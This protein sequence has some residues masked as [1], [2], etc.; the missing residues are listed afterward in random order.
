MAPPK[1][2]KVRKLVP[3]KEREVLAVESSEETEEE[4]NNRPRVPPQTTVRGPVQVDVLPTRERPDRRLAKRRKAIT[5]DKKD[6]LLEPRIAKSKIAGI[7]QSMTQARLK[8]KSSRGLVVTKSLDSS[9]EKTVAAAIS[10]VKDMIDE[11][12][13]Q[14]MEAGP[15]AV[16]VEVPTDVAVELSLGKVRY[17]YRN[18][19]DQPVAP[20]PCLA[21]SAHWTWGAGLVEPVPDDALMRIHQLKQLNTR[22][23]GSEDIPQPKTSEELVKELTLSEAI[24]E[25]IVAEDGRT[26]SVVPLLKYLDTKREK[27]TVRRESGSYVELIKNRTKLKRAVALKREWNSATTMAKERAASLAAECAAAKAILE[28]QED[29]LRAKYMEFRLKKSK[30]VYEAAVQRAERLIVAPRKREHLHADELAKV[31]EQRAEEAQIAKDLCEQIATAKTE[32]KK[33][34]Q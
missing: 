21:R 27:Y 7:W 18:L 28:D 11:P 14:V 34:S 31:E 8:K 20:N 33:T 5:D 17:P 12:T 23:V 16:T 1:T 26:D 25:Q 3:L 29:R 9:V 13:Q 30:E 19:L 32:E 6:L 10:T 24:L 15:S 2:T 22:S 4:D